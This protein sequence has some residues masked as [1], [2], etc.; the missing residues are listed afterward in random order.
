MKVKDFNQS[1]LEALTSDLSFAMSLS[2]LDSCK[3]EIEQLQNSL[4]EALRE[5]YEAAQYGLKLLEE[6]ESLQAKLDESEEI[7]TE[8]RR[9]LQLT[10]E[11]AMFM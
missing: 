5:K 7:L 6:K 1:S 4:K 11:V 10:Q 9:E 3:E 8:L 2:A